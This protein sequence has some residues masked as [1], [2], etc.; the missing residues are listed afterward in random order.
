MI[1]DIYRITLISRGRTGG[2]YHNYVIRLFIYFSQE[3][4]PIVHC[5]HLILQYLIQQTQTLTSFIHPSI[6]IQ[7]QP[8]PFP[9]QNKFLYQKKK[10]MPLLP[11]SNPP[12]NTSSSSTTIPDDF[13]QNPTSEARGKDAIDANNKKSNKDEGKKTAQEVENERLYEERIEEEYAKREG[14]A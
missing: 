5:I 7:P 8:T 11:T 12:H 14:G 10:K 3:V 2:N 13:P 6:Q 1:F 4:P 9:N